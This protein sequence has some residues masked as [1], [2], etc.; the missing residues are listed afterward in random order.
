MYE[1]Y[2]D[3]EST[4]YTSEEVLRRAYALGVASVC[5][6]PDGDEYDR[7]RRNS[8]DTYD[9]TILELAYDEGRAKALDLE[10]ELEDDREIWERL[11]ETELEPSDGAVP[12]RSSGLPGILESPAHAELPERLGLPEFLRRE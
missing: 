5:G 6:D 2:F 3:D 1:R 9:E 10:A 11:V 8:P 4:D 7:L 12:D